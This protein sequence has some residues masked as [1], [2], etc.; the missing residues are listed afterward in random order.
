MGTNRNDKTWGID[1]WYSNYC[2]PNDVGPGLI[3]KRLSYF[4]FNRQGMPCEPHLL[5]R[6][7]HV[8]HVE[9]EKY[10]SCITLLRDY[11]KK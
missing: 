6:C 10:R 1:H 11:K 2:F 5:I 7:K 9:W 3:L 8:S 4:A